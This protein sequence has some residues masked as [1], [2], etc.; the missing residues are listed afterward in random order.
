MSRANAIRTMDRGKSQAL[1][2]LTPFIAL[3]LFVS[4]LLLCYIG[5]KAE[6]I[7]L[8][9]EISRNNKRVVEMQKENQILESELIKL[10]SLSALEALG[11]RMGFKFPTQGDVIYVEQRTV[12]RIV[13]R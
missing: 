9:Y 6:S 1:G 4:A 2:L 5:I 11:I 13:G 7:R 8:G 12:T 3:I 10:T